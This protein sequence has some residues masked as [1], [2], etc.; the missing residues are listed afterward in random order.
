MG[1]GCRKN[2]KTVRTYRNK[3]RYPSTEKDG[4]TTKKSKEQLRQELIE[5]MRKSN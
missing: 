3:N 2:S 4:T 5:R 1:C